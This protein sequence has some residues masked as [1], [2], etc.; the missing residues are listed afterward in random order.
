MGVDGMVEILISPAYH[1]MTIML[2]SVFIAGPHQVNFKQ[3]TLCSVGTQDRQMLQMSELRL[4][5]PQSLWGR[6]SRGKTWVSHLH[7]P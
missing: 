6:V 7:S 5:E 1:I 3:I 4:S 2:V